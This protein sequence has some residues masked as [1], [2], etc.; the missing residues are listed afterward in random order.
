MEGETKLLLGRRSGTKIFTLT[1]ACQATNI[2]WISRKPYSASPERLMRTRFRH[3]PGKAKRLCCMLSSCEPL[4]RLRFTLVKAASFCWEECALMRIFGYTSAGR[5]SL[6]SRRS[7][8]RSSFCT[9]SALLLKLNGYKDW[10][11]L[12]YASNP[13]MEEVH[14]AF[15]RYL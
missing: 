12:R 1:Q 2:E 11:R 10:W 14:A 4:C 15:K 13:N 3:L 9:T 5:T 6:I 8:P 7:C